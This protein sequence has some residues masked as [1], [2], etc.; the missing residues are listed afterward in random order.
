MSPLYLPGGPAR[1]GARGAARIPPLDP[2][3]HRQHGAL[4]RRRR[5]VE[6]AGAALCPSP[7]TRARAALR[8]LCTLCTLCTLRNHP[9]VRTA[10][11]VQQAVPLPPP[12]AG[13]GLGDTPR[14]AGRP[15]L[16]AL[17]PALGASRGLRP[18]RGGGHRARRGE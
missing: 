4:D 7:S 9:R 13:G 12:L 17:P 15:P 10:R 14:A 18:A 5:R 8:D 1:P 2:D 11:A 16:L 3:A 6:D